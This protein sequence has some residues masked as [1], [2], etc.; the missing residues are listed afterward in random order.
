MANQRWMKS[1]EEKLQ[2]QICNT[3]TKKKKEIIY[4]SCMREFLGEGRRGSRNQYM[5]GNKNVW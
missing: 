1:E 4:Y 3:G 5:I 2:E